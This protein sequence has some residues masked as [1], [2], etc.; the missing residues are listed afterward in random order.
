M[1]AKKASVTKPPAKK[2]AD[3]KPATPKV[4]KRSKNDIL[5][6]KA[7]LYDRIRAKERERRK[8]LSR[9]DELTKERKAAREALGFCETEICG[10]GHALDEK[11]P[12]FD[13]PVAGEPANVSDANPS[14]ANGVATTKPIGDDWKSL[15]LDAAKIIDGDA[16]RVLAAG[17]KTLGELH[18]ALTDGRLIPFDTVVTARLRDRLAAFLEKRPAKAK[19]SDDAWRK[20]GL[21]AAG[22][23]EKQTDA[24][25]AANIRTLGELQ[26]AMNRGGM[27]WAKNVGVPGRMRQAIEDVFNAYQSEI[28]GGKAA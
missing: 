5:T 22:F 11:H 27:F 15:P 26:D 21:A 13:Q 23:N 17:I 14:S 7:K 24:L 12:L 1:C 18:A 4:K 2:A 20:N 19:P 25:E 16:G 8:L 3:K 10:L 28:H 9:F 6:E